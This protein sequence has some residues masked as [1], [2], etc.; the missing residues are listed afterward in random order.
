[1]KLPFHAQ[2]VIHF[3][4]LILWGA[5][6]KGLL[7]GGDAGEWLKLVGHA[8]QTVLIVYGLYTPPPSST[9]GTTGPRADQQ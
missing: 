4:F 5:E 2:I 9:R 7:P 6:A 1:M 8:A 3:A